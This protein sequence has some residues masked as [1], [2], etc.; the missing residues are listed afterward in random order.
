MLSYEIT[1]VKRQA[2]GIVFTL[3]P[4]MASCFV[5]AKHSLLSPTLPIRHPIRMAGHDRNP[6]GVAH[7]YCPDDTMASTYHQY[8]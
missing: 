7:S 8:N 5:P 2:F 4:R 6:M 3:V 1:A